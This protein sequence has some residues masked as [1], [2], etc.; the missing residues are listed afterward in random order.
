MQK[1]WFW[2]MAILLLTV[3]PLAAQDNTPPAVREAALDAAEAVLGVRSTNWR[4]QVLN[5]TNDS[6]LGCPLVEGESMPIEVTPYRMELIYA[7]GVYVVHV[8]ADGRQ[9][10]L[11]D[12][13]FGAAMTSPVTVAVDPNACMLTPIAAIAAYAAPDNS[14]VGIFTANAGTA[15]EPFG[16]SSDG[17]WFQIASDVGIG[18]VDIEQITLTGDCSSLP[19]T[20]FTA[21][22]D[23]GAVCFISAAAAFSNVRSQPTVEGAQVAQIFENT[24]YQVTARNTPSDWYYIQPGWVAARVTVQVGNCSA[25]TV[26]DNIVGTGFA[27]DLAGDLDE[28]VARALAEY[29]C[30]VDFSGYMRPRLSVGFANAQIEIGGTPNTLRSYPNVD[31]SIGQ[32]LGVIQLGRTI[33]RVMSGPVC[34]QGFVWWLVEF[35]G[36]TGWTAES[37][38]ATNDYFLEP[39]N[40]EPPITTNSTASVAI[41]ENAI[42][43]N[44]NPITALIFNRSGSRLFAGGQEAGFGDAVNGFVSV[45]NMSESTSEGRIDV[46]T[47]NRRPRLCSRSRFAHGCCQ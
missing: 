8:S 21:P 41:N 9:V 32:R 19:V 46:P 38:V 45:W 43:I 17:G 16:R 3:I 42:M 18:W 10:Q 23:S 35:D 28:S 11:C 34:N 1:R 44:E 2:L 20:A 25:V 26:N 47:G 29:P 36:Q 13:K 15:Y 37:N 27:S 33:D 30:A 6:A 22:D 40:G 14:V 39:L 31:D 12:S 24:L 5:P 7:D 4:F